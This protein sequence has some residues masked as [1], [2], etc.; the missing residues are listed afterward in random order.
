MR[1]KELRGEHRE[2][3]R[4]KGEN[5]TESGE[6]FW[7]GGQNQGWAPWAHQTRPKTKIKYLIQN[8]L[9]Y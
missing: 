4:S 6:V 2:K 1:E 3:D 8:Q 9:N 5:E 7:A